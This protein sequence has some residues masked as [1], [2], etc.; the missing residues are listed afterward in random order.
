[1]STTR[2]EQMT[3]NQPLS[4]VHKV[5]RS[6]VLALMLGIGLTTGASA[7]DPDVAA[8]REIA[9]AVC[10]DCHDVSADGKM[11]QDPPAFAAIAVYRSRAKILEKIVAPHTTM[12]RLVDLLQSQEVQ[13]VVDYIVS[14]ESSAE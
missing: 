11:K 10:G 4:R 8:G 12:P 13:A 1:M 9:A 6:I 3:L 14:L 7:Q 5:R 2:A